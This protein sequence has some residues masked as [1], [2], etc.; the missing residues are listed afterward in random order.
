VFLTEL[1]T[2]YEAFSSGNP[3]PL[4]DL[5]IQYADFTSWQREWLRGEALDTELTYWKQQLGGNLAVLRLPTNRPR[6][7][8]PTSQG[9]MHSFALSQSLSQ[10]LKALSQREAVTLFMTLLA[11]LQT[12]LYRYTG[13]H[14]IIVCS[15]IAN[16]NRAEIE[17]LIG[18]FV[19]TLA[20]RTDLSGNPTFRELLGRVREVALAAY[21]HRE[22]HLGTIEAALELDLPYPLMFS[23]RNTPISRLN[24]HP[25]T[26]IT[27]AYINFEHST[28]ARRDL[29]LA[30]WEEEDIL[31]RCMTYRT[32][33]FD[34]TSIARML[35]DFEALLEHI[36]A[37]PEQRLLALGCSDSRPASA[38][39]G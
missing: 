35:R 37:G 21:T 34:H 36:A 19:N 28:I 24:P 38:S 3:S 15:P 25:Y 29:N 39:E 31:A 4:P 23:L 30:M 16:R 27:V 32:D 12:L 33:V 5:P 26:G 13:Q 7:R 14:D 11:A 22:L 9:A 6:S 18:F 10:G 1:L 20:L 2:L 17:R 8:A